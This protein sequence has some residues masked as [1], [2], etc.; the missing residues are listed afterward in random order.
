MCNSKVKNAHITNLKNEGQA[1][2]LKKEIFS[3]LLSNVVFISFLQH[4]CRMISCTLRKWVLII[5]LFSITVSIP[6]QCRSKCLIQTLKCIATLL[7]LHVICSSGRS[8]SV[9]DK[10]YISTQTIEIMPSFQIQVEWLHLSVIVLYTTGLV[11]TSTAYIHWV[12]HRFI[13]M[14]AAAIYDF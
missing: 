3:S 13:L 1:I 8:V 5:A 7:L 9:S 2:H 12:T 11:I 6:W 10:Q 14:M 4:I